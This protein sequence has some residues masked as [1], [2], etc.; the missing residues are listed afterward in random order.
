MTPAMVRYLGGGVMRLLV[1]LT[2]AI[3]LAGS[4]SAAIADNGVMKKA[5]NNA[6]AEI[7]VGLACKNSGYKPEIYD[8]SLQRAEIILEGGGYSAANAKVLVDTYR[9]Q[10]EAGHGSVATMAIATCDRV[11]QSLNKPVNDKAWMGGLP[12]CKASQRP[13]WC[14]A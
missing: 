3:M 11:W 5:S 2:A 10:A 9:K 6:H 4:M 13:A 7:S 1:L 14:P 12:A 8:R